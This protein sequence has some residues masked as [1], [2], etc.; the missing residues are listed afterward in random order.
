MCWL[1]NSR[2]RGSKALIWMHPLR[3]VQ[4]ARQHDRR[5]SRERRP[6]LNVRWTF[7]LSSSLKLQ[8]RFDV[9]RG[10]AV[11]RQPAWLI[12]V[13]RTVCDVTCVSDQSLRLLA[14]PV[15]A[16]T[17]RNA[18]PRQRTAALLSSIGRG[19]TPAASPPHPSRARAPKVGRPPAAREGRVTV[20][21]QIRTA[22]P[23]AS[24]LRS[25]Q[26][27]GRQAWSSTDVG[28]K[29]ITPAQQSAATEHHRPT[30]APK[31]QSE[32]TPP[33]NVSD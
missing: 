27:A 20:F 4:R 14:R 15:G 31:P 26:T 16:S 33:A 28:V 22:R 7:R 11:P 9:L 8:V 24:P 30:T 32:N 19:T 6:V 5:W 17:P 23:T 2:R 3:Y 10:H 21:E 25:V 1:Q 29:A 12:D 13:Y 18:T